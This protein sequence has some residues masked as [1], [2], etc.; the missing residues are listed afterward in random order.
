MFSFFK[1]KRYRRYRVVETT[2]GDGLKL[3]SWYRSPSYLLNRSLLLSYLFSYRRCLNFFMFDFVWISVSITW[4]T[5]SSASWF[6]VWR[7][8]FRNRMRWR[9]RA[10]SYWKRRKDRCRV[11]P[12]RD[13]HQIKWSLRKIASNISSVHGHG[14]EVAGLDGELIPDLIV[15]VTPE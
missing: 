4:S 6:H 5:F 15:R 9:K 3:A 12:T 2:H 1:T 8:T 11:I 7:E 10:F 13:Y 14:E